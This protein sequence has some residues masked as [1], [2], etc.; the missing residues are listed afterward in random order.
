MEPREI[1]N[2][3]P[4]FARKVI[5]LKLYQTTKGHTFRFEITAGTT[6]L[7]VYR[8]RVCYKVLGVSS[9]W[10]W[11]DLPIEPT[12]EAWTEINLPIDPTSEEW[13]DVNLPIAPTS[14]E[15]SEVPLPIEPT[16]E[17]W[18]EW[19]LPIE[20]TPDQRVWADLPVSPA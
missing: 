15:W 4:Q 1:H 2:L 5:R 7:K 11:A 17:Q 16:S 20:P 9:N 6:P 14:E 3:D 8:A 12:P 18:A 10:V 13:T 19:A